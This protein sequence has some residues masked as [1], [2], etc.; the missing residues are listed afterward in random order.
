[1]SCLKSLFIG[2]TAVVT[3]LELSDCLMTYRYGPNFKHLDMKKLIKK[4]IMPP[5]TAINIRSFHLNNNFMV[6]V[7]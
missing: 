5:G 4:E 1:V 2:M 6:L 3:E 7:S